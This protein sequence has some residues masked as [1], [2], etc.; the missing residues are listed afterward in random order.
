RYRHDHQGL[1]LEEYR[2][3]MG[4]V[5]RQGRENGAVAGGCGPGATTETMSTS[6]G[7]RRSLLPSPPSR[8]M[9]A[10]GDRHAPVQTRDGSVKFHF[11]DCAVTAL[12]VAA[13][14]G[15]LTMPKTTSIVP[16]RTAPTEKFTVN[17]GFRD[18]APAVLAG[19]TNV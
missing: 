5:R 13:L 10:H 9:S 16:L 19:N 17:P 14:C 2:A 4:S 1:P 11:A 7:P 12:A 18:W 6:S 8:R 3:G 15:V